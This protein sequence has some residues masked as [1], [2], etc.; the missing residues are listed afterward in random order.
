MKVFV[1]RGSREHANFLS[2]IRFIVHQ[3]VLVLVSYLIK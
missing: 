1:V 2:L 3:A